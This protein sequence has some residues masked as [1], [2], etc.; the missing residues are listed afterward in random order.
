MPDYIKNPGM[1]WKGSI[2][3]SPNYRDFPSRVDF[4]KAPP[5]GKL[6]AT[7]Q[8]CNT[9]INVHSSFH[10]KKIECPFCFK[11]IQMK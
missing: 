1:A 11:E 7:C 9:S 8:T 6:L 4:H 2:D 10:A 3:L 5:R